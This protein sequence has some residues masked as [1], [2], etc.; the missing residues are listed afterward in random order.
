MSSQSEMAEIVSPFLD[1][2]LAVTTPLNTIMVTFLVY[3]IYITIFGMCIST[4]KYPNNVAGNHKGIPKLY[5][6][7]TI[8]LFILATILY[9][10]YTWHYYHQVAFFYDMARTGDYEPLLA[11]L[12]H[13]V[14]KAARRWRNS[15]FNTGTDKFDC[16][17]D[18]D[19]SV[20][21]NMGLAQ[22]NCLAAIIRFA[23]GLTGG[24][25][26]ALGDRDTSIDSN[27][28]L[29]LEGN[30]MGFSFEV[31]NAAVNSLVTLLTAGRIWFISRQVQRLYGRKTSLMS[32]TIIAIMQVN[33]LIAYSYLLINLGLKSG[34]RAPLPS[35]HCN[36]SPI[37][38]QVAGIAPTLVIARARAGQSIE[39]VDQ[40]VSTMQFVREDIEN[41]EQALPSPVLVITVETRSRGLS[42]ALERV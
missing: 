21:Y 6:W 33:Q 15:Q 4:F 19:P 2:Q 8:L 40:M 20:L 34:I 18:A 38:Y 31:I 10:V 14:A 1:R 16:G 5:I 36:F 12:V 39:N 35:N 9:A 22:D 28:Y 30:K 25:L 42:S 27:R 17:F 41:R 7:S 3:G 23:V 32:Q 29:Y 26:M 13:D 11:Y 37:I 24:I